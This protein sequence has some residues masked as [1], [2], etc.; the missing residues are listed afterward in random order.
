MELL[1]SKRSAVH[2]KGASAYMHWLFSYKNYYPDHT[3]IPH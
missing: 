1:V 3:I 2:P